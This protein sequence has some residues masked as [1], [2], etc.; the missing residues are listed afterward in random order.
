MKVKLACIG[1]DEPN[2]VEKDV[3]S[4][5]EDN[6]DVIIQGIDHKFKDFNML[7]IITYVEGV[8]PDGQQVQQ[9][10]DTAVPEDLG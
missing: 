6:D 8:I 1:W 5:L 4:W 9:P 2:T 3:N 10:D 7:T